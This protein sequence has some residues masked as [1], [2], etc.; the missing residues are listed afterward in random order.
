MIQNAA[1]ANNKKLGLRSIIS[2]N[3]IEQTRYK[4]REGIK[5]TVREVKAASGIAYGRP[6]EV[7]A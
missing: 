3:M 2:Y 7:R 6:D 1:S 4:T 5:T